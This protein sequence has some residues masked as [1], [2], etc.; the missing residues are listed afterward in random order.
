MVLN[1]NKTKNKNKIENKI[2]IKNKIK[3]NINKTDS[4]L[5]SISSSDD[6]FDLSN[7]YEE[8]S[9]F[10]LFLEIEEP[11]FDLGIDNIIN[12]YKNSINLLINR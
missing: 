8:K 10:F 1:K 7:D 6:D 12:N 4:F 3:N 9:K 2:E 11:S 5:N